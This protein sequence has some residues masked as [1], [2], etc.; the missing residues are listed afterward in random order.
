MGGSGSR[1]A[2]VFA[3]CRLYTVLR[4]SLWYHVNLLPVYMAGLSS[5]LEMRNP[6]LLGENTCAVSPIVLPGGKSIKC[7]IRYLGSKEKCLL[8]MKILKE[9]LAASFPS[10]EVLS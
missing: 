7:S 8:M 1:E 3:E 10:L 4:A 2:A 9:Y 6:R 5:V